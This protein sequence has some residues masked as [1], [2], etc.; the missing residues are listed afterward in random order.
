MIATKTPKVRGLRTVKKEILKLVETYIKKAE[1]LEAVNNNFIP[2][3]LDAVLGDYNRNVPTARDAEVL[4]VVATIV[5]RLGVSCFYFEPWK[6][7]AMLTNFVRRRTC[8]HLKW[9]RSW[10]LCLSQR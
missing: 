3:L 2:P 7:Y 9:H 4:N 10:M 1:D 5:T 8:L 6:V